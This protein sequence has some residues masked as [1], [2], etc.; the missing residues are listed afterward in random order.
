MLDVGLTGGVGR[1]E[2]ERVSLSNECRKVGIYA[3]LPASAC[4]DLG[5]QLTGAAVFLGLL[6]APSERDIADW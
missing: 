5:I 2:I 6:H 1:P 3:V 4:L